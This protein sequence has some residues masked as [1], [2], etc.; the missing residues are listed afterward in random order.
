MTG[1]LLRGAADWFK[2]RET[3]IRAWYKDTGGKYAFRVIV[4]GQPFLVA[5][6]KYLHGDQASFMKKLAERAADQD[7]YLLLFIKEGGHRVVFDPKRVL[8]FGTPPT[9]DESKRA[10]DGE[11]W[12]DIPV[13]AAVDFQD[14]YDGTA[15]P[16]SIPKADGSGDQPVRP[17]DVTAWGDSDG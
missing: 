3:H 12:L 16:L 1:S 10:K 13:D 7:A 11:R 9:P 8:E 5:A 2:A 17:W 14:W 4:D 6:K 15:E